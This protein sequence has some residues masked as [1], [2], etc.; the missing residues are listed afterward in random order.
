MEAVLLGLCG[1]ML[2]VLVGVGILLRRCY[3][4]IQAMKDHMNLLTQD[5]DSQLEVLDRI[6]RV[7]RAQAERV[8]A[9][10]GSPPP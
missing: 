5:T 4:E 8:G 2:M 1:I 7:T 9:R 3:R 10:D 6:D